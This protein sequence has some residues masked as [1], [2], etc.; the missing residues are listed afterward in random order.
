MTFDALFSQPSGGHAPHDWQRSLAERTA[1]GTP[2]AGSVLGRLSSAETTLVA[3]ELASKLQ[4][5]KEPS[6]NYFPIC[7][8]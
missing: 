8:A 6:T 3:I 1:C 4:R 2:Q 7:L 5:P